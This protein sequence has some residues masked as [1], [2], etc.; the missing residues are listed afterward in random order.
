MKN[1]SSENNIFIK[2]IGCIERL[3]NKLPHPFFL[4][5]Y[6]TIA[7]MILSAVMAGTEVSYTAAASGGGEIKETTIAVKNLLSSDYLK[8][9]LKNWTSTYVNFAPLGLV[10]VM[11]LA[12]GFAQSTGLFDAFMKKT[13]LGA[14]A[15]VITFALA[16]VGVCANAASN[17]GIIFGA[18]IGAA[19]FSSL[20]RN[21]IIGAMTGYA[22]A[23]GGF[24]ANLFPAGT[25]VTLAGITQSA[26][27]GMG[28]EAPTHPLINYYFLF[29]A[30]FTIALAITVVSEKVMPKLVSGKGIKQDIATVVTDEEKRG[31]KFAL[32]AL[33]IFVIIMLVLT[34][35]EGAF[36]R[37]EDGSIVPKSPLIDSIVAILFIF[38]VAT[39][40]AYGFGAGTIKTLSDIPKYMGNGIKDSVS[41]CV[42]AFPASMFIQMFNDSKIA[43]VLA[44]NGA[45][46]LESFNFNGIPL[47]L[48]FVVLTILC[49]LFMTSASSKWLILAPIFVPMFYQLGFSPALTQVA[50]RIGDSISNPIAP[51]NFFLPIILGIMNKYKGEDEAEYGL[52]T[53]I[54]YMLPYSMG[55]AIALIIQLV[56]WMLVCLPLGPGAEL[57]M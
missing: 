48:A 36:F 51:I 37:A 20:G 30:T 34:L 18:T 44:V 16:V 26:A 3:G 25:D 45:Q 15:Y 47:A 40:V 54:S 17:A 9:T 31:L 55:I 46:L 57:F 5:I 24:S 11:M 52:G 8:T 32:I 12:I 10:M 6:L 4:F 56:L 29:T 35:P 43:N 7:I 33:V 19:L 39:G 23:H 53:L 49:N 14:P 1:K 41:F 38:F 21:P 28:I 50:Y 27:V 22:A 42:I 2:F 13:L